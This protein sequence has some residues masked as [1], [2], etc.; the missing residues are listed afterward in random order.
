[1]WEWYVALSNT[2]GSSGFG[3]NPIGWRDIEAWSAVTGIHPAPFEVEC[4]MEIECAYLE[5]ITNGRKKGG[6]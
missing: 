2:R 3:P 6:E 1:V 5:A 4:L